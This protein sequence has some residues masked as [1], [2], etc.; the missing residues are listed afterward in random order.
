MKPLTLAAA[1]ALLPAI[2]LAQRQEDWREKTAV[3]VE[4]G[5][6]RGA[7]TPDGQPDVSG[8]WSNTIGNHNTLQ[9]RLSDPADGIP[10][11]PW[12]R[13]TSSS[14]TRRTS[15]SGSRSM[16]AASGSRIARPIRIRSH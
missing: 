6:W 13:A 4:P 10:Y 15:R 2:A 12:A 3:V 5:S 16:P 14:A 8:H 9:G 1:F 7:R 11:Q